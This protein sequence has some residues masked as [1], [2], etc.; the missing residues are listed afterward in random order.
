[1]K[2]DGGAFTSEAQ[3]EIKVKNIHVDDSKWFLQKNIYI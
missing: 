2:E 1:M 3:D